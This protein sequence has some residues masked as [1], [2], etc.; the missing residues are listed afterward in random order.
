MPTF[1]TTV[2][3]YVFIPY[4]LCLKGIQ[5]L[6]SEWNVK[7]THPVTK[8][9]EQHIGKILEVIR[10]CGICPPAQILQWL[11]EIPVVHRDLKHVNLCG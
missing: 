6:K 5:N 8:I 7:E 2:H 1:R 10:H 9:R 11:W 4:Y 3:M